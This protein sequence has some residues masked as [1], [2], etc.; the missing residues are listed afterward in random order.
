MN[1]IFAGRGHGAAAVA[2]TDLGLRGMT[3]SVCREHH[4]RAARPRSRHR[5]WTPGVRAC[6]RRIGAVVCRHRRVGLRPRHEYL[7]SLGWMC[8]ARKSTTPRTSKSAARPLPAC[9]ARALVTTRPGKLARQARAATPDSIRRR[10][11]GS[12]PPP[13]T[14]ESKRP[15]RENRRGRRRDR[16]EPCEGYSAFTALIRSARPCLASAK[17]IPVL[18]FV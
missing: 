13:P 11:V 14:Q 6:N 16:G 15:R 3:P 9:V 4:R 7:G 12:P 8:A 17:S 10:C 5:A 18:G 2:A 1:A